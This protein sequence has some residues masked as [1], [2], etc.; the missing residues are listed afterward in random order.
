M[1]ERVVICK[2]ASLIATYYDP[3]FKLYTNGQMQ[4]YH[5]FADGH[6]RMYATEITYAVEYD[7]EAWVETHDEVAGRLWI[8]TAKGGEP[9]TRI[10]IV[11]IARFR[12]GRLHRLWELT[13]PDW[14]SLEAFEDYGVPR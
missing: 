6:L 1:F 7:E 2:D 12:E 9:P 14:S 4:D 3:E 11:L 10:E 5:A 8:T 13:W